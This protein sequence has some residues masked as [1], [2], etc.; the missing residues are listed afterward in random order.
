LFSAGKEMRFWYYGERKRWLP[1][2]LQ[3]EEIWHTDSWREAKWPLLMGN[4][5]IVTAT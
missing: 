2:C 5:M 1:V 3:F 4:P